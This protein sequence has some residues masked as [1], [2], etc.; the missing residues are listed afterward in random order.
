MTE[1]VTDRAELLSDPSGADT[2]AP[3][4]RNRFNMEFSSNSMTID[5]FDIDYPLK[6]VLQLC[7]T[8]VGKGFDL[9][10]SIRIKD[11]FSFSLKSGK[12]Q[13]QQAKKGCP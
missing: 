13:S 3:D 11:S 7:S 2:S 12:P 8:L 4:P 5:S 1:S 9:S 6:K 10:I